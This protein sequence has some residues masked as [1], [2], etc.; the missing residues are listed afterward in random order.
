M[1][2]TTVLQNN[3]R[4]YFET[5]RL[6]AKMLSLHDLLRNRQDPFWLIAYDGV[7]CTGTQYTP[8]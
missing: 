5:V 3:G 4:A 1:I 7:L 8:A 2:L 6:V